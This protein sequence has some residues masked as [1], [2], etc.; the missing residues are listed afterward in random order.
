MTVP[1]VTTLHGRLDL[2]ELDCVYEE[3]ADVPVISI[4]DA[5]RRP[6]PHANWVAT[7]H[8]GLPLDQFACCERPGDYLAFLGRVSPE[9][10]LD[11]AVEIARRAGMPLRVAA[12]VDQAD[13]DY[14]RTVEPLLGDPL[15]KFVG[16]IGEHE[17]GSFLGN[18]RALLFPIDWPEPFG[19]VMI[20]AMAC[21]LPV[22]AW[23]GGSV[24]EVMEDGVTGF[25]VTTIED[26]VH[27]VQ[28]ASELD[29]RRCRQVFERRFSAAR[30]ANDYL[31]VY[32]RLIRA[33]EFPE[34]SSGHPRAKPR[35][36]RPRTAAAEA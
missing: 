14:F 33:A 5:Q 2:P 21:G 12:K 9:K 34:L 36:A 26:A 18:A 28:R 30:M 17:K 35:H 8:H 20:E 11:R 25:V 16:E 15:V 32:K 1:H 7:V 27:A 24:A 29:R 13:A 3:F 19:L 31:A 4:S 23:P 10:G 22:I 6:L